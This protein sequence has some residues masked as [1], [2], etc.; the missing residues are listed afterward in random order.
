M[1][2]KEINRKLIVGLD[3][4]NSKISIL[5]GEILPD[6]IIN[7]I[8]IGNHKSRGIN[9]NS[10]NNLELMT[11]CIQKSINQAESMADCKISSVYLSLS[12]KRIN[13]QNEIGIIPISEH[14]VTQNDINNVMHIA[15]SVK[16]PEEHKII[17]VIP[18]EYIIDNQNGIKN[19]IGFS[20][21][22][23][24]AKVHLITCH[25]DV[26]SNI[27]KAVEKCGVRV[28]KLIFSGIASS[29][30]VLTDEE[31]ELGVCLV[32]IG[33]GTMD[34]VVY[35][36]G[37]LRHVKV[38]PYAGNIVTSDIAYAFNTTFNNAE[39]IKIRYGSAVSSDVYKNENIDV[40]SV[41]KRNK[42]TFQKQK[43]YEVIEARYVE[44]LSLVKDDIKNLKNGLNKNNIKNQLG[45][46]IVL[47]G[48][49]A[50]I[51][52]LVECAQKVFGSCIRIGKPFVNITELLDKIQ[53]PYYSTSIGLLIYGKNLYLNSI[54][55]N[56]N[57]IINN[58]F[59]KIINWFKKEL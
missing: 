36:S 12:D 23:M 33:G 29:N 17:H 18:Q 41:C 28:D 57:D 50:K 32:D 10:I 37:S 14:E 20:G 4:G 49:G 11:K 46:G 47:T 5:V 9:N 15:K 58:L 56:K 30:A 6:K 27:I 26:S 8:G 53:E 52:G 43:L 38:I 16:I 59:R 40:Q 44:L 19:P 3:V 22:R 54:Y 35:I 24:K 42:I 34:I 45:A 48:G 7:V 39:I 51:N 21:V 1:T 25:N 13:C 2:I 31:R 55:I